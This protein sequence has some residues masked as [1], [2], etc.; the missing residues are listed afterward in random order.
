[1]TIRIKR[2]GLPRITHKNVIRLLFEDNEVKL[3][4]K[5]RVVKYMPA[6]SFLNRIEVIDGK[7]LRTT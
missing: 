1:M 2:D 7:T 5:N 3:Y 6:S 4:Y